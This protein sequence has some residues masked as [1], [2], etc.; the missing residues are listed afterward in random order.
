MSQRCTYVGETWVIGKLWECRSVQMAS[1]FENLT[2][3]PCQGS[4]GIIISYY[5]G[6]HG[7]RDADMCCRVEA[8]PHTY[9]SEPDLPKAWDWLA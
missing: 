8:E 6:I 5:C 9:I 4:P 1:A 3:E 7:D 2:R